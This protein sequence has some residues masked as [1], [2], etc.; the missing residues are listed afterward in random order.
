VKPPFNGTTKDWNFS[1][2]GRF[3]LILVLEVKL[4]IFGL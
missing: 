2:G 1:V 3:I 4:N